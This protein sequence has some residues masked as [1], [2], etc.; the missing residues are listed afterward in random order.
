MHGLRKLMN[1]F[2]KLSWDNIKW[3][4]YKR[5]LKKEEMLYKVH[6]NWMYLD[7]QTEGISHALAV[8]GIR[9]ADK[10][11]IIEQELREGMVV[12][13]CGSNIGFY[14]LLEA[15]IVK[16][17][18][19]VF[20]FEPDPRNYS[21]LIKNININLYDGI[22]EPIN[23]AVSDKSGEAQIIIATRSN[24]SKVATEND[25]EY[26]ER[27]SIEDRIN[28]QSTSVD[29]FCE[30]KNIELDFV[31]M[32]IEGYEVEV[33][34]GMKK[35]FEASKK[36]FK[37]LL[38]LHPHLY[39]EHRCFATELEKLFQLNFKAKVIISAGKPRPEKF[40]D[41]GYNPLREIK[42]DGF[43]RGWYEN[44]RSE[45]VAELTCYQPKM[46]RYVL[47]EKQ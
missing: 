5:L 11:E 45:D 16:E 27:H 6:G 19:K 44:V 8:D 12:L 33:F 35:T 24:L 41:L 30:G 14:P 34:R 20:T 36:G 7:L 28:I 3:H 46:S 38:E 13:D 26:L 22:I 2:K 1:I 29:E 32:D 18:G 37:V 39:S 15:T 23:M 4:L 31:R 10:V 9:E 43:I 21:L 40:V 25:K 42:S 17:T 47:L